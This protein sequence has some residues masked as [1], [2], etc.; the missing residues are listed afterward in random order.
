[1]HSSCSK[2]ADLTLLDDI[3]FPYHKA[4]HRLYLQNGSRFKEVVPIDDP[5]IKSKIH[6][7]WRLQYLKDVVLA[8]I[9]DDPTFGVLNTLIFYNHLEIVNYLQG[10]T[11]FQQELFGL[12]ND[13]ETSLVK[14]KDVV[15]FLQ[16]CCAISKNLQVQARQNLYGNLIQNGLLEVIVFALGREEV[17]IR[18]AGTDILVAMIDHD[19]V[20]VRTGIVKSASEKSKPLTETLIEL[21]LVEKDLGVKAQAA[22]AIKIVLDPMQSPPPQDAMGRMNEQFLAKVRGNPQMNQQTEH[23]IQE[24]YD[25]GAPKLF[26]PLKELER[27]EDGVANLSFHEVSLY[28]HLVDVLMYFVRQHQYR[29]KFFIAS[30]SIP[31]QVRQL[32]TCPQK[33]MKLGKSIPQD[34]DQHTALTSRQRL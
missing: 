29:S 22:D 25:S 7:T 9:L 1:M 23:F 18:I 15:Y 30:E 11:K 34:F 17:P 13:P 26:Q 4:N 16:Q 3:E 8:R 19:P 20:M 6:T 5:A 24:F 2:L 12:V 32:L 31:A 33:H 27:R 14:K 10:N 28:C 21:L